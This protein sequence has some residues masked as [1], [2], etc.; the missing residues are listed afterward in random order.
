MQPLKTERIIG[1]DK[2]KYVEFEK[3]TIIFYMSGETES[4]SA[5]EQPAQG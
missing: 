3:K 5:G 4:G 1:K 2:N